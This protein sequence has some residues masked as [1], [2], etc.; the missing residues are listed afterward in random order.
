V[1]KKTIS[2]SVHRDPNEIVVHL[3]G[4]KDVRVLSYTRR[5]PV[6][7]LEIE[8]RVERFVCP[9]CQRRAYVKDRPV[10]TL[11]DLPFGGT[12]MRV[13]WKKHRLVCRN[14]TC[15]TGSFTL[16]DHRL[17]A[18]GVRL[19]TRAAKWATRQVGTGRTVNEVAK[20]LRC[21][22]D[23]VARALLR[24]GTALLAADTQRLKDTTALGLDET[25]FVKRGTYKTKHWATTICDVA[26]HQ[27][28]DL[29]PTRDYTLVATHLRAQPAHRKERVAFG[30]CDMSRTYRAVYRVVYPKAQVVVDRFH[31]MKIA[32]FAIDETRR[33]VQRRERG[34]RGRKHDPLYKVRKLLIMNDTRKSPALT[35]RMMSLLSLGDPEGEVLFAHSIK[36]ALALYYEMTNAV[37]A[38]AF[39]REIID[40][41]G[42]S[43]S[44]PEVQDLAGTLSNWFAEIGAWH[45]SRLSNGPTEG[46]NNLIK[47]TKRVAFGFTNFENYRIRALLYAG[48]PTWRLLDSIVV[49]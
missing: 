17:A 46:M 39:L 44:P 10:T 8:Q 41:A 43:S 29:I 21:S 34:H 36:E 14:E 42:A 1:K 40:K 30:C 38:E 2:A 9:T 33:R 32:N 27:L 28:I 45:R 31:V 16:G 12:P 37:E 11:I 20:E 47:R 22:W 26:N 5:G 25:L 7:E 18:V 49:T 15:T 35:E 3:V 6:G 13:R 23:V 48:K 24:Y 19:T 4:L